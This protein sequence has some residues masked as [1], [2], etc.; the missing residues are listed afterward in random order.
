MINK[1]RFLYLTLSFILFLFCFTYSVSAKKSIENSL[2]RLHIIANSDRETD[3]KLKISVRDAVLRD[4]SYLFEDAKSREETLSIAEDNLSFIEEVAR[5][6][7]VRL[8]YSYPVKA[9]ITKEKFPVKRY[10]N[11]VLP[12][13]DYDAVKIL[14]GEGAG[15]NWWCVMY[16][17][18]C[19]VDGATIET[20]KETLKS[21]LTPFQYE[22]IA[23]EETLPVE[24]RFKFLE[25]LEKI[26][27]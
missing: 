2:L 27:P 14:I 16:P 23:S 3:Q 15:K 10:E 21:S 22:M 13:G 1:R 6:E 5:Q 4:C 7:I 17:P 12:A 19:F 25:I 8:G 20:G 24:F 11:I 9:V 18:L 26:T